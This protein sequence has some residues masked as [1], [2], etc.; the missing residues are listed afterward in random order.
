MQEHRI[1]I[2]QEQETGITKSQINRAGVRSTKTNSQGATE[3]CRL[4][5]P[6][7]KTF[8]VGFWEVRMDL[9]NHR[10]RITHVGNS[11]ITRGDAIHGLDLHRQPKH[12]DQL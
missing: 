10:R 4:N 8:Y 3:R 2:K 5:T 11:T 9:N 7:N 6:G 12:K 1:Q